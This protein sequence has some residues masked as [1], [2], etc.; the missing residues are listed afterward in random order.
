[1]TIPTNVIAYFR[2]RAPQQNMI[3]AAF[4][5]EIY[6]IHEESIRGGAFTKPKPA[7]PQAC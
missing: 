5:T 7:E 6:A 3:E 1:M 2:R 4:P